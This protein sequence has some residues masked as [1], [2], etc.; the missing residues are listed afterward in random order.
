[1]L[2][3]VGGVTQGVFNYTAVRTDNLAGL[4]PKR[5]TKLPNHTVSTANT[6]KV[7]GGVAIQR[8]AFTSVPVWYK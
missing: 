5:D 2:R 6:T 3:N 4:T 1:M 7:Y 8:H